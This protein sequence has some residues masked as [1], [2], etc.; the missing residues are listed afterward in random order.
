MP[1][2]VAI[3][4]PNREFFDIERLEQI[5]HYS[6][7]EV[8][9]LCHISRK[10]LLYY[11]GKGLIQ[12]VIRDPENH[13]RYYDKSHLQQILLIKELKHLGFTL[14]DIAVIMNHNQMA[15]IKETMQKRVWNARE[16]LNRSIIKYEQ[17]TEK[18]MQVMQ[19]LSLWEA[20]DSARKL[21]Q[22]EEPL[23]TVRFELI[24]VPAQPV[25]SLSYLGTF[26]D[27]ENVY[28]EHLSKLYAIV[29]EHQLTILGSII[30][31]YYDHF[32]PGTGVFDDANKKIE[33]CLAVAEAKE[34]CSHCRWLKGFR[35]VSATHIGKHEPNLRKTY[36]L[37]LQWAQ[38]QHYEVG[39]DSLEEWLISPI[40]TTQEDLWVTKVVIPLQGQTF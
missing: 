34:D 27:Q 5:K 14:E 20:A 37:L 32:Q 21:H 26:S 16:E 13:Y 6:V 17:S 35:G 4:K 23:E 7:H 19:A 2:I 8:M 11:E 33:V 24:D 29:E 12:N 15:A 40:L 28:L 39:T 25:V 36:R 38:E 22:A 30:N 31:L 3:Q 1:K 10:Q 18:Y 9:E